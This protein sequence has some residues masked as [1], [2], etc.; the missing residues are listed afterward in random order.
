[1]IINNNKKSLW[2]HLGTSVTYTE[3]GVDSS[4]YFLTDTKGSRQ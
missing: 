2:T 1:M 3:F 4:P